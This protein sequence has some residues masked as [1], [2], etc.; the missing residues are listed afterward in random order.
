MVVRIFG[1]DF[2]GAVDAGRKI[3]I[4]AGRLADERLVIEDCYCGAALP[5]STPDR[6]RC[7][8]ALQA[9]IASTEHAVFG[10]DF[11][12]SLPRTLMAEPTWEQFIRSFPGRYGTPQQFRQKCRQAA[13]GRELKRVTDVETRTPFSPYNLRLYRQTYYGLRDVVNPLVQ[14]GSVCVLPLQR[15]RA[16]LP[17][18]IEICPASTLKQMNLYV[19]YKG[20]S[21][22]HR[23]ARSRLL[24]A[25]EKSGSLSMPPPIRSRVIDD[26]EGDALDSV[27]G[28]WATHRAWEETD[29]LLDRSQAIYTIEGRV[30]V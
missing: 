10:L 21:A 17:W 25:I 16:R 8:A 28:A 22:E 23:A 4:A 19:A 14:S 18:L 9:F 26:P 1:V 27:I 29:R 24:R 13:Q 2:S 5:H 15:P 11:P 20:R 6:A 7:L 30:F 12:L 3:W